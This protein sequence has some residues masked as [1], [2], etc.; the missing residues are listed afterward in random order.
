MKLIF[1]TG[2]HFCDRFY[3]LFLFG[4]RFFFVF[5]VLFFCN[6]QNRSRKNYFSDTQQKK[7]VNSVNLGAHNCTTPACKGPSLINHRFSVGGSKA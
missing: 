5:F 3:V 1:E 6:F 4:F 7:S 2:F